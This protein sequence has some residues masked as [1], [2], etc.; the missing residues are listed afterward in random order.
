MF[1]PLFYGKEYG[2][3]ST[4]S[5]GYVDAQTDACIDK[6]LRALDAGAATPIWHDCD[7]MVMGDAPFVPLQNPKQ[8]TFRSERVENFI[9]LPLTTS[10]DVTQMW[11]ADA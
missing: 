11:L 10:G 5:G 2:P 4:N 1:V 7:R 6:A 8:I 9:F 3:G